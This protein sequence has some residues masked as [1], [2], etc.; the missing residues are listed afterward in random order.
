MPYS[1]KDPLER[2]RLARSYLDK[3]EREKGKWQHIQDI[4]AVKINT[5]DSVAASY[6]LHLKQA[7]YLVENI[8]AEHETR[9][10]QLEEDL[11]QARKSQQ[12]LV[13]DIQS[14]LIN[15]QEANEKNKDL[16]NRITIL[17][18]AVETSHLVLEAQ[19]ATDL[20][21]PVDLPIDQYAYRIDPEYKKMDDRPEVRIITRQQ[22]LQVGIVILITAGL[23]SGWKYYAGLGRAEFKAAP[24]ERNSDLIRISCRNTGSNR[25]RFFAPWPDGV[26]EAPET[27]RWPRSTLGVQLYVM[28]KG[29]NNFQLLPSSDGCW[30]QGQMNLP[31]GQSLSI[32]SDKLKP[33][34]F[35]AKKLNQLGIDAVAIRFVFSRHGGRELDRFET[36]LNN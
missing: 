17:E 31:V 8:R 29:Q 24:E 28:E 11:K 1:E 14:G 21:E 5:Y 12:K 16:H 7:E 30:L 9:L 2:F 34:F 35:D 3:V 4:Q 15:P 20:G 33:V 6:R 26:P 32:Q 19:D 22:L 36:Y 27:E 13:S 10:S 25:I 23:W 18:N